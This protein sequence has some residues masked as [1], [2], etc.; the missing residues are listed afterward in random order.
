MAECQ[1]YCNLLFP[2][3]ATLLPATIIQGLKVA[4]RRVILCGLWPWEQ[5]LAYLSTP[6]TPNLQHQLS[7]AP[8]A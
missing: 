5:S 6:S 1:Q 4:G 8:I 3:F 7:Q 2:A